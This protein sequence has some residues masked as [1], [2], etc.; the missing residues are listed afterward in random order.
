MNVTNA[1]RKLA[2]AGFT[3]VATHTSSGSEHMVAGTD[4]AWI[5]SHK[6][7][8]EVIEFLRNGRGEEITCIRTKR[9]NDKDDS[10]T[11]YFVGIWQTN[12]TQAINRCMQTPARAQSAGRPSLSIVRA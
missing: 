9:P 6:D 2:K 12:I 11:D 10:M 1:L 4:T 8:G 7:S 5:A 3:V